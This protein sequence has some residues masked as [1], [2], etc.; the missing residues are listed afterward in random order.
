MD[1]RI[2]SNTYSAIFFRTDSLEFSPF[3]TPEEFC[4][5]VFVFLTVGT[6][7]SVFKD[8]MSLR[9]HKTVEIMVYLTFFACWSGSVQIVMELDPDPRVP[10]TYRTDPGYRQSLC[11]G[12]FLQRRGHTL[13]FKLTIPIFLFV[14]S[15]PRPDARWGADR[16]AQ[17]PVW[18]PTRRRQGA[19]SVTSP[20]RA[21][22]WTSA[23]G[24]TP[25]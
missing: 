9:S 10:N 15:G 13:C 4:L 18:T 12:L 11:I 16:G 6:L 20:S 24:S 5:S 23:A 21:P 25:R 17:R 3:K 19:A 22:P 7:T 2:R 8:S 14:R 1:P